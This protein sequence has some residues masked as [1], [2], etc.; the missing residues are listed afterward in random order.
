MDVRLMPSPATVLQ[1]HTCTS[2]GVKTALASQY[3]FVG[4]GQEDSVGKRSLLVQ[5]FTPELDPQNPQEDRK[6]SDFAKLSSDLHI[7]LLT[8][9]TQ[10]V[11]SYVSS[12]LSVHGLQLNF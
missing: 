3:V 10:T 4:V 5:T 9:Q 7:C 8:H 6:R 2:G 12:S 11:R 1:W